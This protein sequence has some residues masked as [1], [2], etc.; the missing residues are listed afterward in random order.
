MNNGRKEY[1]FFW[2]I[3]NYSYC[4]HKNGKKLL[5]P[6]FTVDKLEDTTWALELYPR[7]DE[8][9]EEGYIS[10]FL[11]RS[12][13]DDGPENVSI[14]YELSFRAAD[15]SAYC[16]G[17]IEHEFERGEGYGY[18]Q[19][20][21]MDEILL[22]KKSDYFPEDTLA[23]R[24]MIWKGEGKVEN[25][26]QSSARTRIR[27]EKNSFLHVV[28]NFST[29]QPNAKH[30]TMIRPHSKKG[31]FI[32][33]SIYFTEENMIMIEIVL[34]DTISANQILCK[35]E[36]FLIDGSGNVIECGGTDNR[37]EAVR[38][39]THTIL[40]SLSREAVLHR[41]SEYLPDD[42]LSLICE[43]TFS[44]GIEFKTIEETLNE[45][46]LSLVKQKNNYVPI[47]NDYKTAEKL[48]THPSLLED[49]KSLYINQ[50]LTDVEVK[51]K[52]KS[53]PAHKTVLCAR[54]PVFKAMMTNDMKE[55]ITDCIHVDDLE[56][57]IMQQLLFFL[58]SDIIENFQ[59]SS[60][61]Q[62]YYAADKYQIGKLKGVCSSFLVGNLT[63]TNAGELLLL[64]DTHNDSDLKKSVE[65]FILENE[66]QVFGS[67]EWEML[68]ETNPLLVMKT[69]HL[70]YKRKK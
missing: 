14:K 16:H 39:C 9:K 2:F 15:G 23:V 52:T 18:G 41:K 22:Q 37:Y 34:S 8:D 68:M 59:W 44:S 58:Y 70:K 67:K 29:L 43:C 1:T 24:C 32:T 26:G 46:P 6:N 66:E 64:A 54:S 48:S 55:K 45:I 47:K 12:Q 5:S 7:G 4:Y 25:I 61:T 50:C 11:Y 10:L 42:K 51:T 38:K 33:S 20:L 21:K 30:T 60:A 63:T 49:I 53:F 3:E 31:R 27:I 17:E 65:D 62:L 57:D 19:F 69:M 40:L 56:N 28:E 36:L 13:Q 35:C